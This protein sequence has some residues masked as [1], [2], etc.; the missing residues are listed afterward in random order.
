[1]ASTVRASAERGGANVASTRT[2]RVAAVAVDAV[3]TVAFRAKSAGGALVLTEV[4]NVSAAFDV[5]KRAAERADDRAATRD[6]QGAAEI[7]VQG[8]RD[9]L[10]LH[11]PCQPAP[12]EQVDMRRGV[13]AFIA[14]GDK[15]VPAGEADVEAEVIAAR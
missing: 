10:L 12:S 11:R 15:R 7:V 4:Q 13:G 14:V 5:V 3:A 9:E 8:P 2:R 1:R 6:V